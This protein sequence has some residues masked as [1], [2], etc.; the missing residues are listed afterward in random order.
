MK[1]KRLSKLIVSLLFFAQ[2]I[3]CS[4]GKDNDINLPVED[5]WDTAAAEAQNFDG[6]KLAQLLDLIEA[7][8]FG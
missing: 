3:A 2:I 8:T 1:Q 7:G 5:R 6:G 4:S